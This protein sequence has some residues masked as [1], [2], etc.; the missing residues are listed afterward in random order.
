[1]NYFLNFTTH[2]KIRRRYY[3]TPKT[4]A[5]FFHAAVLIQLVKNCT[6]NYL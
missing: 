3:V 1:M 5:S 2:E 4:A 6:K